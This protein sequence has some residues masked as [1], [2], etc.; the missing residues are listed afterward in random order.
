[1]PHLRA[2][3]AALAS[4]CLIGA[5]CAHEDGLRLS[6]KNPVTGEGC[7][8]AGACHVI[9]GANYISR[10]V[11]WQLPSGEFVQEEDALPSNDENFVGCWHAG[12]LTCFFYPR[13]TQ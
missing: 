8:G 3:F 9:E 11:G 6:N 12:K 10:A 2:A 7:C 4:F 13:P 5:A 1:M